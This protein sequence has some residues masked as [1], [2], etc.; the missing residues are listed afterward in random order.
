MPTPEFLA[1]QQIDQ[2]LAASGWTVQNNAAMNLYAS[3]GVAIAAHRPRRGGG[4]AVR[5]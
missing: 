2:F 4:A 5:V 1:R 3:R